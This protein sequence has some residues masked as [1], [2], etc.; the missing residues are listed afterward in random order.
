[1]GVCRYQEGFLEWFPLLS[2]SLKPKYTFR[3]AE[4]R[5]LSRR[6]PDENEKPYLQAGWV[7]VQAHCGNDDVL[8][9]MRFGAYAGL[10]SWLEAGPV[11]GI[12]T[13]R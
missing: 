11:I 2:L 9:G 8:L 13:W 7:V 10:S 3:R 12:G 5:V 4:L 6:K 1:M